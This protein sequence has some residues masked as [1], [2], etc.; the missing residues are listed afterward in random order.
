M[1][2]DASWRVRGHE[3]AVAM[4]S[5]SLCAPV[6]ALLI[7][8]P[9]GVG[10]RTL[11]LE[12]AKALNCESTGAERPCQHCPSCRSIER[13]I[14]PDV[15]LIE[16][17]DKERIAIDQI[18]EVREQLVLKPSQG[19]WRVVIIRADVLTEMAAGALLKTLE[20]PNSQVVLV[21]TARDVESVPETIV[22]RCRV[23]VCSLLA[24][25][26]IVDELVGRGL[27][28]EQALHIAALSYGSI[29]WAIQAAVDEAMAAGRE[30]IRDNLAGWR[31]GSLLNRLT[32]AADMAT[33]STKSDHTRSLAIEELAIMATW[34]RDILLAS[35][36]QTDLVVNNQAT[37]EI[38]RQ[39]SAETPVRAL[40]VLR[41]ICVAATRVNQN[42]EPRLAL[43]ALAVAL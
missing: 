15:S 20:E 9:K 4:L 16:P 10:K 5:R 27:N 11:G 24:T 32:A 30:A 26:T 42:V 34:W 29:G 31:S 41:S 3:H 23:L 6:H 2:A 1:D 22:S 18:R 33:A 36:G 37:E 8:G 21:L 35:A 13:S 19:K 12:L 43:E 14:S 7:V 40:N 25:S 17:E 38:E 39:S 28:R